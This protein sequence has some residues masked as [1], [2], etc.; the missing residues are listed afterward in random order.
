[1]N[2][3]V[4]K[5]LVECPV[6]FEVPRGKILACSNAHIICE[7]CHEKLVAAEKQCPQGNCKYD[8]PARRCRELEAIVE[9]A[10]F[11]LNCCNASTGCQKMVEKETMKMHELECIFRPVPCPD[12][13]T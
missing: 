5:T 1:M 8:Q 13:V 11:D 2:A 4:L 3:A 10:N 12:T 9:N 7:P 6:C